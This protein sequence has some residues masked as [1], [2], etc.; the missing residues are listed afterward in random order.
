MYYNLLQWLLCRVR[1]F[2]IE[3]NES[4]KWLWKNSCL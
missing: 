4:G 2:S 1:N 3:D